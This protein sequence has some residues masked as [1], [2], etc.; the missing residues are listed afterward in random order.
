VNIRFTAVSNRS[1]TVLASESLNP[2][3]WGKFADVLARTNSRVEQLVD[4]TS[5]MNRFYR[6]VTPVQ[7]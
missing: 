5:R 6:V 2:A 4:P 7:P 3:V 1:Y